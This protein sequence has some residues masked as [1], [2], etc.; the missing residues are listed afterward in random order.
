MAKCKALTAAAL[1]GLRNEMTLKVHF[2]F[3]KKLNKARLLR[4]LFS[5]NNHHVIVITG[6]TGPVVQQ[7][8]SSERDDRTSSRMLFL[9]VGSA[10]SCSM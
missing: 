4:I 7:L 8:T 1:K 5:A 6:T 2:H 9:L 10:L 3:P